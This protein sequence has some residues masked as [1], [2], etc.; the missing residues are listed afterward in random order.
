MYLVL[1]PLSARGRA[2]IGDT[3]KYVTAS[4][5]RIKSWSDGPDGMEVELNGPAES[6]TVLTVYSGGAPTAVTVQSG[7]AAAEKNIMGTG[8]K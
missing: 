4:A 6:A 2:L 8:G 5:E 1:A 3:G 7:G